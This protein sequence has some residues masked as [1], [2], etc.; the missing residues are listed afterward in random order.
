MSLLKENTYVYR[1]FAYM[2]VCAPCVRLV[3]EKVPEGLG[4][5]GSGVRDGVNKFEMEDGLG[6]EIGQDYG[7][8]TNCRR[9]V[10]ITGLLQS[11]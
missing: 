5:P 11:C 4:S 1:C 6:K 9:A 10:Y 7:C 3:R 8:E 2:C